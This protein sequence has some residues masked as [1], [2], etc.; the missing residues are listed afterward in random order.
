M[1]KEEEKMMKYMEHKRQKNI[2]SE[3]EYRRLQKIMK[4]LQEAELSRCRALQNETPIVT[5]QGPVVRSPFS[6]NGG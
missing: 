2:A 6:V 4:E 1:H 5:L 3:E